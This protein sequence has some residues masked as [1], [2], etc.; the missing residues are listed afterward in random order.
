MA[1]VELHR[2]FPSTG[3]VKKEW[4][5]LEAAEYYNV[6]AALPTSVS[7][8]CQVLWR[9]QQIGNRSIRV[10]ETASQIELLNSLSKASQFQGQSS[11]SEASIELILNNDATLGVSANGHTIA[12]TTVVSAYFTSVTTATATTADALR[13]PDLVDNKVYKIKN[14]TAVDLLLFPFAATGTIVGTG[15]AAGA[16][17]TIPSGAI[18]SFYTLTG[19]TSNT[20]VNYRNYYIAS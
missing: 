17:Y 14:A 10:L 15:L 1:K 16:A 13:L 9:N 6:T 18:V 3:V 7:G 11:P 8:N 19:A 5:E 2:I 12:S 20:S 4:A